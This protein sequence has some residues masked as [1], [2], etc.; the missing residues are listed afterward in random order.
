MKYFKAFCL[1]RVKIAISK[2]TS[3][4]YHGKLGEV[5]CW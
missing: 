3:Y 1:L 4:S 2:L 5:P